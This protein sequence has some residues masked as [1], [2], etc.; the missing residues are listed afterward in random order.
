M[1]NSLIHVYAHYYIQLQSTWSCSVGKGEIFIIHNL[2]EPVLEKV[3]GCRTGVFFDVYRFHFDVHLGVR[4]R[5]TN[6]YIYE[7]SYCDKYLI[8][9]HTLHCGLCLYSL[10]LGTVCDVQK[11]CNLDVYH[12]LCE[13]Y[14]KLWW[15]HANLFFQYSILCKAKYVKEKPA[16]PSISTTI[17]HE[18]ILINAS[19]LLMYKIV[20]T[21]FCLIF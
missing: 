16:A 17:N 13:P 7:L 18:T 14:T 6:V 15:M 20:N 21:K 11:V 9:R 10:M 12:N 2:L 5:A 3:W 19:R 1:E 4:R 8:Y